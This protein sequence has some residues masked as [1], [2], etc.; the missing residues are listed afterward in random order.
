MSMND[1]LIRLARRLAAEGYSAADVSAVTDPIYPEHWAAVVDGTE[2]MRNV[3]LQ[4]VLDLQAAI[5]DARDEG[6]DEA[7]HGESQPVV[8]RLRFKVGDRVTITYRSDTYGSVGTVASAALNRIGD[9][10][11]VVKLDDE[12]HTGSPGRCYN[13]NSL[14]PYVEADPQVGDEVEIT[15]DASTMQ[16]WTGRIARVY[17]EGAF[18]P[19]RI[20]FSGAPEPGRGSY[21]FRRSEF[22]LLNPQPRLEA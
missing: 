6:D 19:Y 18:L 12:A 7:E 2:Y 20:D 22:K 17:H 13:E 8:P 21:G 5:T 16:G 4:A 1:L 9:L 14:I 11:Y 15:T 10:P 3:T